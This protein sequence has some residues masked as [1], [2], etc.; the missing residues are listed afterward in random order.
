LEVTE[1]IADVVEQ[2]EIQDLSP[3]EAEL[4]PLEAELYDLEPEQ[5]VEKP[6]EQGH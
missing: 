2:L 6:E 1:P 4:F 5:D 3:L